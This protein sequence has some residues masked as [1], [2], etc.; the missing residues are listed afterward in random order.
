MNGLLR[1][2]RD[3][4]WQMIGVV[5]AVITFLITNAQTDL[6][7][8]ELVAVHVRQGS[9][10]DQ[11]LPSENVQLLIEGAKYDINNAV[12]DY[13]LLIN[14]SSKPILPEDYVNP[15]EVSPRS[16]IKRIVRVESCSQSYAQACSSDGTTTPNG[17]A[18][19][20]TTWAQTGLKWISNKPLI[21]ESDRA[22]ILVVFEPNDVS[23]EV[24]KP[25]VDLSVRIKGVNFRTFDDYRMYFES[26]KRWYHS[27]YT[28]VTLSGISVYWFLLLVGT[29]LF[30]N[31]RVFQRAKLIDLQRPGGVALLVFVCLLCVSTSEILVDIY[32]NREGRFSD[33]GIHPIVWPL[34]AIHLLFFVYAAW[35]AFR[36]SSPELSGA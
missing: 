8:K 9:L 6:G 20:P 3:P 24:G 14:E 16:Y 12:A 2:L 35:R 30:A 11:W 34:L 1:V 10:T 22:C 4:V 15:I 13:F 17:G 29:L 28:V 18:Y 26:R 25:S 21:N 7:P 5:V 19:T 31:I 27:L 36:R 33:P 23:K 32:V